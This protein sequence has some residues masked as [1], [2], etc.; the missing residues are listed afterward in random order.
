[1]PNDLMSGVNSLGQFMVSPQMPVLAGDLAAAAMGPNQNTWQAM[2]GRTAANFGRSAIA[3]KEAEAQ[4][5][6]AAAMND[7]LKQILPA[8]MGGV[9]L[10]PDGTAGP[11]DTTVKINADGTFSS[12]TKGNTVTSGG[13]TP[14]GQPSAGTPQMPVG[15][16]QVLPPGQP[17]LAPPQAPTTMPQPQTW[18]PRL[19]PF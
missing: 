8:L 19:L 5:Q 11:T 10:T 9:K 13:N 14:A 12:T 2:L 6:K 1:M 7:W 4:G 16:P 18:N 3:A 15:A 17:V